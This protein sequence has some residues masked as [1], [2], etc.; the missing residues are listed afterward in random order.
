MNAPF[1]RFS[2]NKVMEEKKQLAFELESNG[3]R[4]LFLAVLGK[5]VAA[6]VKAE[7]T[8]EAVVEDR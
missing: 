5:V 2:Q 3:S 8:Q 4:R 7:D 6:A 1:E